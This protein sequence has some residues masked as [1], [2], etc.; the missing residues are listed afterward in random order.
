MNKPKVFHGYYILIVAFFCL[1]VGSG[2][3]F[4]GF[5]IF[6]PRLEE[7]LGWGR[8]DMMVAFS[9]YTLV[10]GLSSP[11]AGRFVDRYGIK[12]VI[13]AGS[14][15][16]GAGFV[17]L[18]FTQSLWQFYVG[19]ILFGIGH[20][21]AH[22]VAPI[23]LVANWFKKR[24][25]TA[26]GISATGVGAGGLIVAPLIGGWLIPA[27]DWN[28]A[29]LAL[30]IMNLVPVIPLTLWL[31][32]DK[33]SD[34]GLHPDGIQTVE[35]ENE[36]QTP[37]VEGVPLREAL[38][39]SKLWLMAAVYMIFGI[40]AT[41]ILQNQVPFL[42]DVGYPALMAAGAL[43]GVGLGSLI[44]KFVFGWLCDRIPPQVACAISF[45]L[46]VGGSI[47]LM[48]VQPSSSLVL[49]WVYAILFGLGVGGW[50]PTMTM[51]VGA[52]YGLTYYATIFGFVFMAHSIGNAIGPVTAGYMFDALG[53][54]RLAFTIFI[55]MYAITIPLVMLV[56][57]PKSA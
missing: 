15:L 27:F 30:A 55:I 8:G 13:V 45:S 28:G 54:Y 18:G 41:A 23:T 39:S 2:T 29:Y 31:V 22:N 21:A 20:S 11:F 19:Y 50:L 12:R 52:N 4:F 53:N 1:F 32:K 24:R 35:A 57:R 9:V 48:T 26:V 46:G 34:M 37:I 36:A 6:T 43:G 17:I 25:G 51:L 3:G 38:G 40:G 5:S 56:R 44:G 47:I 7:S 33:P 49:I 14:L 16:T 10:A 42:E